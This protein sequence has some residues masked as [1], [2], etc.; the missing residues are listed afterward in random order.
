[1]Q[2]PH[3]I[4]HSY[5]HIERREAF[6]NKTPLHKAAAYGEE[7]VARLLLDR[8]AEIDAVNGKGESP[9]HNARAGGEN[10]VVRLLTDRGAKIDTSNRKGEAPLQIATKACS[11]GIVE[12]PTA[13]GPTASLE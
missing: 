10:A 7:A 3:R 1:V 5:A 12:Q 6:L 13:M 9:L 4:V 8:G 2:Q 11:E